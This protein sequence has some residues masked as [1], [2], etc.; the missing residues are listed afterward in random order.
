[1]NLHVPITQLQQLSVHGQFHFIEIPT[2]FLQHAH[3]FKMKQIQG[4][5]SVYPW[6]FQYVFLKDN[7]LKKV[8]YLNKN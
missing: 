5:V 8:L 4:I 2:H 6:L 1:M 7:S 3:Y